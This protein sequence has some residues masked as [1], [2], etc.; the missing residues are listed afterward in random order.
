MFFLEKGN[1][2]FSDSSGNNTVVIVISKR[3]KFPSEDDRT[4]YNFVAPFRMYFLTLKV[5]WI[6]L[7]VFRFLYFGEKRR[8]VP[9]D[10]IAVS[11]HFCG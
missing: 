5:L 1:L 11:G 8:W 7:T 10:I 3:P 2:K 6:A 4:D 9:L